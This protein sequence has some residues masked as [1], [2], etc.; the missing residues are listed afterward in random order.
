MTTGILQLGNRVLPTRG[1]HKS[2]RTIYI[3]LSFALVR[4]DGEAVLGAAAVGRDITEKYQS[5]KAQRMRL[6]ELEKAIR[7]KSGAA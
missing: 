5:E 2:G 4:D 6:A 1:I 7:E 3:D